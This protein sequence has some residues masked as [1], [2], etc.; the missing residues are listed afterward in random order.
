MVI[1]V[2]WLL[3]I[4]VLCLSFTPSSLLTFLPPLLPPYMHVYQYTDVFEGVKAWQSR[5]QVCYG[6]LHGWHSPEWQIN[7][8]AGLLA[9]QAAMLTDSEGLRQASPGLSSYRLAL[10]AGLNTRGTGTKRRKGTRCF[11]VQRG[12]VLAVSGGRCLRCK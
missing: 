5:G 8:T 6:V 1:F 4:H 7:S 2:L 11:L 10:R 12:V 9:S 3:D